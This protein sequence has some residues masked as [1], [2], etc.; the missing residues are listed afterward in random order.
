MKTECSMFESAFSPYTSSR[1]VHLHHSPQKAWLCRLC[2]QQW[3]A[4]T[5]NEWG[6]PLLQ[7]IVAF[8]T[9]LCFSHLA[10]LADPGYSQPYQQQQLW[11]EINLGAGLDSAG[12]AGSAHSHCMP[13]LGKLLHCH[14]PFLLHRQPQAAGRAN[15]EQKAKIDVRW[16]SIEPTAMG[17][18]DYLHQLMSTALPFLIPIH[19]WW[20]SVKFHTDW[21]GARVQTLWDWDVWGREMKDYV[22]KVNY[23]GC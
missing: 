8:Q 2:S 15:V 10:V 4:C 20:L 12:H 6:L 11:T 1:E 5:G 13:S 3:V 21:K 19:I 9:F 16:S 22:P 14:H 18:L 7:T 23:W 17:L